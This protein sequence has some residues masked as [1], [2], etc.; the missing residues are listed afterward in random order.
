MNAMTTARRAEEV[1]TL[2]GEMVSLDNAAIVETGFGRRFF[3]GARVTAVSSD[4]YGMFANTGRASPYPGLPSSPSM[5][6]MQADI[7]RWAQ[8]LLDA[9]E[10]TA[11]RFTS[12]GTESV[13]LA[14]HACRKSL[15]TPIDGQAEIIAPYSAHPCIDK[16]AELLGLKLIRV[17]TGPNHCA[18]IPAM[19]TAI[20]P[21]TIMLYASFPSYAYG[22]N[23]DI[24]GLG[25]LARQ[26]GL[27]LHVDACMSGFLAPFMRMNGADIAPCG[28]TVPGVTS[29]SADFHKHGY[30]AKGASAV[31]LPQEAAD[32]TAFVYS[33][34]PLPTM[35][36]PS[37]AGTAPG[38]PLASAWAVIRYLDTDGYRQLA[39][40]L[41]D[42]T[43][44][45]RE[46]VASVDGF[47]ILGNPDFSILVVVSDKYDM[48]EIHSRMAERNWFTLLVREPAGLHLNVGAK[49]QPQAARF[50]A[51]LK[52]VSQAFNQ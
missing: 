29:L 36:T 20:T 17:P 26:H 45:F 19:A 43:A 27:W 22:L 12:G 49:D 4:A 23:D 8:N 9:P 46:A 28:L 25:A 30:S 44:A 39:R 32:R 52:A 38:A 6:R 50:A 51:D 14:V 40:E 31:F 35:A 24:E 16:A 15:R 5:V 41:Q 37:L 3:P 18:D 33:E 10:G 2:M 7:E 34:H 1:L 47:Q 13:I 48:R 42:A 11:V 21:R